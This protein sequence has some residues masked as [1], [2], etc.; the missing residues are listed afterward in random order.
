MPEAAGI[1]NWQRG[2]F[3]NGDEILVARHQYIGS[4]NHR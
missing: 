3:R 4:S 1:K 2:C